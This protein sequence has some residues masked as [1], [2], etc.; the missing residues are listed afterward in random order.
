MRDRY[1]TVKKEYESLKALHLTLDMSRGKPGEEQLD[2]SNPML[3]ALSSGDFRTEAGADCRNYGGLDGIPEMKRIFADI[4]DVGADE[5]IVGGNSSLAMMFDCLTACAE[6]GAGLEGISW[7]DQ[8]RIKFLC[9]AP[10]YDRHFSICEYLRIEMIPVAMKDDGPDMDQVEKLARADPMIKGM[11]CVPVYSNPTGCVYAPETV[12]R[13]ARL[14]PA[15]RDFRLFWDNAYGVHAF[16]EERPRI[17]NILRE[18]EEA[19]CPELPLIFT[20]LSKVSFAGAAVAAAACSKTNRKA[21]LRRAALE[22]PSGPDK[23]NQLRHVRF[24]QNA[25]GVYRHM[26][27]MAALIRPKFDAAL[28]A[29]DRRLSSRLAGGKSAAM[30]TKPKGGYFIS[31]YTADGCA[32]RTVA[33]CREAGVVLTPAGAAYP[34]GLDP[35]DSHIRLAPTYPAVADLLRAMEVFCVSLELAALEK[36][37]FAIQ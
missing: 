33:L 16:A 35:K 5:V 18:C 12:R 1:E 28:D 15:A 23:L 32:A 26:E 17:P 29:L 24:F 37:I 14:C 6:Y 4:L 21:I 36:Q 20:S 19:G 27:K 10:G 11:W 7:R 25:E 3:E 9:P 31:V 2:L 8:G 22:T 13:L 30:W 34:Y